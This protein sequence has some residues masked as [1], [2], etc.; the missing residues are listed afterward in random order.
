VSLLNIPDPLAKN[1]LLHKVVQTLYW[2]VCIEEPK[3]FAS[4]NWQ[5]ESFGVP[6]TIGATDL[7]VICHA[8]NAALAVIEHPARVTVQ[9]GFIKP[10]QQPQKQESQW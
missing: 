1:A 5:R 3:F 8:C 6:G 7:D 10:E 9:H 2:R 4:S